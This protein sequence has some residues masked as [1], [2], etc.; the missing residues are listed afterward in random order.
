METSFLTNWAAPDD[1]IVYIGGG[2][3]NHLPTLSRMFPMV[4]FDVFDLF[5]LNALV[6]GET[7]RRFSF[8]PR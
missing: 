7:A 2:N 3:G 5:P 4:H 1:V 8:I 6:L